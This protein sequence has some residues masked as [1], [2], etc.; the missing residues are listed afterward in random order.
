[1]ITEQKNELFCLAKAWTSVETLRQRFRR[2]H[3]AFGVKLIH[4]DIWREVLGGGGL[5]T[6]AK[7]DHTLTVTEQE[8][9]RTVTVKKRLHGPCSLTAAQ[10]TFNSL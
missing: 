9:N 10:G 7:T 1:M 8:E 6:M 3:M 4:M 5:T 2:S